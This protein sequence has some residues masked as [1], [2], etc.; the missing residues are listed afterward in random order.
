M[1]TNR[2]DNDFVRIQLLDIYGSSANLDIIVEELNEQQIKSDE[3]L[4]AYREMHRCC[5]VC[6][7]L[8]CITTLVGYVLNIDAKDE[9]KDLNKCTCPF[10]GDIHSRHDRVSNEINIH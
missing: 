9:Y 4:K 5:P 1:P 10:C 7:A 6:G 3:F 2:Y 8:D